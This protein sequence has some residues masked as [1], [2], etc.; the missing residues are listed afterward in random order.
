MKT[1]KYVRLLNRKVLRIS[2]KEKRVFLQGLISNDV[3]RISDNRAIYA[4]LLT[5]QGKYLHDFFI[6]EFGNNFYLDCEADRIDDLFKRFRIFKLRSDIKIEIVEQM[7]VTVFFGD[8]VHKLMPVDSSEGAAT[9]WLDGALFTDPRLNEI[10]TR[11]ILPENALKNSKFNSQLTPVTFEDYDTL[12]INLGLPD[13]SRD[14][15]IEK[16]ILLESGFEELNGVDF[17][18]G[19]Y[20]GQELTARTKHRGL[21]KK[22]LI[23]VKF[24]GTPPES[25]TEIRQN[26]KK[27]GEVRSVSNSSA[28]AILSIDSLNKP[29]QFIAGNTALLPKKTEWANF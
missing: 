20:V 11:A 12:R 2:G 6:L 28:L 1:V 10:G 7:T 22:R 18:K 23:P 29:G 26:N 17:E 19:C 9:K 25:G 14:L 13:S 15:L 4:A 3:M 27:V 16:S 24:T 5:P 21:I 8:Y